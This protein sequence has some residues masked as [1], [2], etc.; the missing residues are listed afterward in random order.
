MDKLNTVSYD[1]FIDIPS[2]DSS[3]KIIFSEK[4][5]NYLKKLIQETKFT[6]AEKGCYIVGRKSTSEKGKLCFYFDFYSSKFKTV[7]GN[8]V[9]GAVEPSDDNITELINELEKYDASGINACVMHFHTHNLNEIYSAYSDQDFGVYAT[10]KHRLK[11]NVLGLLAAPHKELKNETFEISAV[12]AEYPKIV[13]NR[14][15]AN[16]YLIPNLYYCKGGNIMQIGTYPKNNVSPK[17]DV[18]EISRRDRF[19]QNYREWR[20]SEM[21]SGLGKNPIT[22]LPIVDKNVGYIDVNNSLVFSDENLSLEVPTLTSNTNR[23]GL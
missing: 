10:M 11:C 9:D 12:I 15:C 5:Y 4:V 2:L 20:G 1:Q 16:F 23:I 13:E 8:Y 17:T 21:V 18:T 22:M 6:E 7:D 19:V 14:G 3:A